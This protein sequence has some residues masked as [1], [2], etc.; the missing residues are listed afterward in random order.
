MLVLVTLASR[1]RRIDTVLAQS[2]GDATVLLSIE[3]GQYYALNEVGARAWEQCDGTR[4]LSEIARA[5]HLEFDAP[6][7]QIEADI[8]E[9]LSDLEGAK[10]VR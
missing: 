9:L 7:S 4:D 3:D 5:L 10:L 1:P 6:L 8:L 2:A